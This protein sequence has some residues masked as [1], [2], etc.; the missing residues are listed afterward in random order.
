MTVPRRHSLVVYRSSE[1]AEAA[2]ASSPR[3][4]SLA[5]AALD[6][7]AAAAEFA[8]LTHDGRRVAD[9]LALEARLR[10]ADEIVHR[11]G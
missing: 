2:P 3:S 1:R 7:L 8:V 6:D 5:R 11:L 9:A 4:R 10:Q